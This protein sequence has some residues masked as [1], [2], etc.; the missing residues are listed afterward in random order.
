MYCYNLLLACQRLGIDLWLEHPAQ[1]KY[2]NGMQRGKNDP[3]DAQR[4]ATYAQRFCDR[5]RLVSTEQDGVEHLRYLISERRL[6]V[7]DCAKYKAQLS[8]QRGHMPEAIFE[9]KAL[10]LAALIAS[11]DAQIAKIERQIEDLIGQTPVLHEHYTLMQTIP[12]VGPRLA[13]YMLVATG[14]FRTICSPRKLCC[15]A[16]IAP[17]TYHSGKN[18]HSRARVSHRADKQLKTL[19][20]LAALSVIARPGEL[21]T[22]YKR[23]VEEGKPKMSVINAVRSKL[24]HRIF[25]VV[26]RQQPYVL[27][28]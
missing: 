17:F 20:H 4:I 6:L 5:A 13:E 27:D 2:S 21:Q 1:I 8:D 14:G 28:Y 22:Y 19:L 7:A 16:G 23:K 11:F 26:N 9:Q 3:L 15:H 12:G 10:R 25:S 24:V 18:I